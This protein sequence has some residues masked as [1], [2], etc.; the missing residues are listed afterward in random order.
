[1]EPAK[2]YFSDLRATSERNLPQKLRRLILAAG[3]DTIDF[4][5]Q[6]AAIK[7][8]FGEPGNLSFLRPNWAKVVADTVKDL[9][10]IPFL[11]DCNTLY[12]GRRKNA[13]DHLDAAMENGFSPLSTGC[14]ILIADGL[15]GTDER[16]VP[17][18]GEY[19]KAAKIG[20][21]VMDADIFISLNHFKGHEMAGFGG[22]LKNIGMGCGSRAG[23]MEMHAAGKPNVDHDLC[24]GC[25]KCQKNCAHDAI[26][27]TDRKATIHHD[28]CVGCGRC[29]GA[30]P[31]DAVHAGFDEAVDVMNCKI[32]EY[33]KA[34]L[35]GRPNFHISLVIDVSPEC[36]CDAYND[37]PLVPNIGM[38]ASFD[39]VALD[40]TCIDA[41]LSQPA[42]P[43]SA[44]AGSCAHHDHFKIKHPDSDWKALLAHGEK[45]GLG[46]R[47]YDLVEV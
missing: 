6:F 2:V 18:D 9:G 23:K 31:M 28:R 21:A 40:Q 19:V 25:G 41:V 39:P 17:V 34:V 7:M 24:I 47:Q 3:M 38:Y 29:I 33:S 36:D 20:A 22:A 43:G 46:T 32:A 4:S 45:I 30:C 35:Q 42:L 12:V 26:T 44:A 16:L 11:T 5:H 37:Y 8:H 13:P 1:M 10:G 14:Q 27:I 15:K